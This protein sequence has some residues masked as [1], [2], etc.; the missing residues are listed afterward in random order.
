[1]KKSFLLTLLLFLLISSG[2]YSQQYQISQ[3][4]YSI[5]GCGAKIFGT[6]QDYA[7]AQQVPVDTKKVF[8]SQ[9][10]LETYILDYKTKLNNLRAFEEI[11]VNYDFEETDTLILVK[12]K[13]FVKDSFHL[14]AIPGPK[15][16]SNTGLILKLKI[17]DSNFLGSLN[18]LSSDIYFMIPT[19][20][21][22]AKHSELGFNFTFD[23]PFKAGIFNALWVNDFGI[24]YTFGNNMPEWD[25]TTGLRFE[26]P[27]EKTSIIFE[28][29]QKLVNNF[30]YK[31]FKDNIYFGDVFKVSSPL[32]LLKMN[33]FGNLY[34]TPYTSASVCWDFN[35][36][37]KQNSNLSSPVFTF[38]HKLSFGRIDWS[39]NLRTGLSASL[40]N[41]YT[42]N[43][44]RQR[45]Y[46][47]I[48]LNACAFKKINLFEDSYILRN[49]GIAVNT[50]TF[51][52]M[53]NPN[54]DKYI[55][56]DGK[57]IGQYLRGIRDSQFYTDTEVSSLNTTSA[58]ILNFD[59]PIHLFSTNFTKSFLKY[60]NFDMQ[61]SPFVDAALC[62]NKITKTF[63]NF[64]DGYYGGGLEV[65]V[66]PL[67]WSGITIRGSV[68][69]DIG[70]QIFGKQIHTQWRDNVSKKEFS[71]GFGLHY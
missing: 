4:E 45:F 6:T 32:T 54:K 53:F 61:L 30:E 69:I 50:K 52:Y 22:D 46:P 13:I 38:G 71:I 42:W 34:Y 57:Q 41:H 17:K 49:F 67:K 20:E 15:Y 9:E 27:F 64:K 8:N 2:I 33:Y 47:V 28:L 55:M 68:G 65:I 44:Q 29:D 48:E 60:F 43:F 12:L 36:I 19:D 10:E 26:L 5:Q 37:S 51:F 1:M 14:F 40:D 56:N 70:R 25:V 39:Q 66:Y 11:E 24:S 31:E 3:V 16:D 18:T 35:G 58:F 62:Y 63:F 21:S 59:L 23:Y 7:L